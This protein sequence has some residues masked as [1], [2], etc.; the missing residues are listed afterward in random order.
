MITFQ[1]KNQ[2]I[3]YVVKLRPTQS[4]PEKSGSVITITLLLNI[5]CISN[6]PISSK[7]EVSKD[8]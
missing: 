3:G 4:I 6:H 2:K 1:K 8:Y 7:K 5:P